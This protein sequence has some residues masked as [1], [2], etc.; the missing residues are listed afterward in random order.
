MHRPI[1]ASSDPR[2]SRYLPRPILLEPL[3]F[4]LLAGR[5]PR[6]WTE[7]DTVSPRVYWLRV[8]V[9]GNCTSELSLGFVMSGSSIFSRRRLLGLS[10]IVFVAGGY[11]A[12]SYTH[13]S[14]AE[15]TRQISVE[16]AHAAAVAG[17]VLLVDIRRPDEWARTGVGEGALPLDMRRED[18]L[19]ALDAATQGDRTRPLALICARG[20]RSARMTDLLTEAGYSNLIDVPEGMLGSFAGSGWLAKGLPV[21]PG[22]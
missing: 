14:V 4:G 1:K 15:G 16:Q 2:L 3:L 17:D 21:M 5:K 9:A 20:V 19:D 11:A 13:P 6:G 8:C 12:W 10:A 18:F 22:S 7:Q